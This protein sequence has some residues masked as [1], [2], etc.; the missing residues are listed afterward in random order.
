[1]SVT[2]SRT[3]ISRMCHRSGAKRDSGRSIPRVGADAP[4][5]VS[6]LLHNASAID[7][8]RTPDSVHP[9]IP[10]TESTC[11]ALQTDAKGSARARNA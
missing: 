11:R 1:M 5:Y 10:R 9:S 7:S 2:H 4:I 8:K 6:I 3:S